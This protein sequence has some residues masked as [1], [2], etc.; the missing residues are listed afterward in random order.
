MDTTTEM[1]ITTITLSEGQRWKNILTSLGECGFAPEVVRATARVIWWDFLA[2]LP[3]EEGT[4]PVAEWLGYDG[5]D[6]DDYHLLAALVCTGYYTEEQAA[7][8]IK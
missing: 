5:S 4:A 1:N 3:R 8:R 2:D 6:L 7:K